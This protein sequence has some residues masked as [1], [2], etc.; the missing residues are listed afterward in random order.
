MLI[1]VI[2]CPSAADADKTQLSEGM[3]IE[4]KALQ[5][6]MKLLSGRIQLSAVTTKGPHRLGAAI[7]LSFS[8]EFDR[9]NIRVHRTD[10]DFD[11]TQRRIFNGTEYLRDSG[12]KDEI[13]RILDRDLVEVKRVSGGQADDMFH[14]RILG[15]YSQG[16]CVLD[17][18]T[19]QDALVVTGRTNET[20][21]TEQF[22]G[23]TVKHISYRR[24]NGA[25]IDLWIAP[26]MDHS[27]LKIQA[28]GKTS[29]QSIHSRYKKYRGAIWYPKT[30]LFEYFSK[31]QLVEEET[32][33]VKFA[34][35]NIKVEPVRFSLFSL[36]PK[37]GARVNK[38]GRDMIWNGRMLLTIQEA[39]ARSRKKQRLSPDGKKTAAPK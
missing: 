23:Q 18:F 25:L 36:G 27:I 5:S 21:R 6:R 29:R 12:R 1:A 34:E 31:G 11:V 4:L 28:T 8:I 39:G 32:V 17:N 20:V 7:N 35:F 10:N 37:V 16:I 19:I 22:D 38:N 26:D 2:L 15:V 30:V 9:D 14:P 33:T 24:S 13:I 3:K